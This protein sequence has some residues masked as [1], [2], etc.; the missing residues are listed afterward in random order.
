MFEF[1]DVSGTLGA[2]STVLAG[3]RYDGLVH[4][5]GGPDIPAIGYENVICDYMSDLNAYYE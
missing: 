2:Q 3:G 4:L 1:V 5:L